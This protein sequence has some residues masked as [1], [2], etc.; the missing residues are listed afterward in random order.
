MSNAITPTAPERL[1]LHRKRAGKT[2]SEVA[3]IHGVGL[4]TYG[5]WETGAVEPPKEAAKIK[6]G[7]LKPNETALLLRRRAGKTQKEVAAKLKCSRFHVNRMESG[8]ADAEPLLKLWN[9]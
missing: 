1:F 3:A 7:R 2:Q 4:F 5:Q 9:K 8:E 6:L